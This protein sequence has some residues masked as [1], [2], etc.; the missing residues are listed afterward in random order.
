MQIRT[1]PDGVTWVRWLCAD[2]EVTPSIATIHGE[3]RCLRCDEHN[4][5]WRDIPALDPVPL[6]HLVYQCARCGQATCQARYVP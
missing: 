2:P 3:G 1:F 6:V 4:Q 5:Q